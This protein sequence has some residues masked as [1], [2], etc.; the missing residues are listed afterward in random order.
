MR[1]KIVNIDF[2]RPFEEQVRGCAEIIKRGG[3]VAFPTET[4]YGLGGSALDDGAA[5]KIYAAKGRP[6]DNP[7]IIHIASPEDAE[8]YCFT[9]EA[10]Y[11]IASSFMPGPITVIL[12][13]KDIIP[14]SVTG[15]L[16]TVAVRCPENKI[17]RALIKEAGV[18][19]AAPS[20]NTSGRPSPTSA[21]HVIEDLDSKI[22]AIIDGGVSEIGLESTIVMPK[23]DGI[24]LLRPGGITVE[25]LK[26]IF[27]LVMLD[28]GITRK[29]ESSKAPLAPGMKYRHYAP[30]A[31]VH[32]I[33]D[34]G[35]GDFDSKAKKFLS[36]KLAAFPDTGI[37]CFDEYSDTVKGKNVFYFGKKRD[38]AEHAKRLFDI[39]RRFDSTD[40]REIYATASDINGVG[41]AIY[42]RMLKASGF[43]TLE[44]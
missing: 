33:V 13:K 39:L 18:P 5:K 11:K 25:M 37:I 17:A 20:A 30:R 40:A 28:E 1:T 16:D 26:S 23:D 8:R 27:P 2:E 32:L 12:P 43:N 42:N 44:I 7:L 24:T 21:S 10:Y 34:S 6:S 9:N 38:D 29:N 19:I 22:D 14:Y 3:L 4:V 31:A 41:L 15:G 36:E 35:K